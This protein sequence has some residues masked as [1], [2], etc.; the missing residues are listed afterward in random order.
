MRPTQS[1]LTCPHKALE[2]K[3][4]V[5]HF[6]QNQH[7]KPCGRSCSS[8]D[9]YKGGF[10]KG[11]A[12]QRAREDGDRFSGRSMVKPM[13][14]STN[15]FLVLE[16]STVGSTRDMLTPQSPVD[17]PKTEKAVPQEPLHQSSSPTPILIHS[18]TL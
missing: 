3:D 18:T 11:Q 12:S 8:S 7:Q 14:R 16:T 5:G 17:E 2:A 10:Q 6:G 13:P 1:P 15:R 4:L 9:G